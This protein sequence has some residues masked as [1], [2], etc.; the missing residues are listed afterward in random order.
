MQALIRPI[1]VDVP[2]RVPTV[3]L[4]EMTE[5]VC[6]NYGTDRKIRII[7]KAETG[8][9]N[10]H[11]CVEVIDEDKEER[12][13]ALTLVRNIGRTLSTPSSTTGEKVE[14][15]GFVDRETPATIRLCYLGTHFSEFT[16]PPYNYDACMSNEDRDV[17][18]CQS[19]NYE[20][21]C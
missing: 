19:K 2:M 16:S 8:R 5:K 17:S 9:A 15:L 1:G 11:Y 6:T 3:W 13:L 7:I 20:T 10:V 14:P 4:P 21:L 12:L 18:F